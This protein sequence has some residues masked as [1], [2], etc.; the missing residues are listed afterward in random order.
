MML[1]C[2]LLLVVLVFRASDAAASEDGSSEEAAEPAAVFDDASFSAPDGAQAQLL[3]LGCR[4][5]SPKAVGARRRAH[6]E[7]CRVVPMAFGDANTS[8]EQFDL[9]PTARQ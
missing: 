3:R 7:V 8:I 4:T 5:I 2:L 6:R 9:E 1:R